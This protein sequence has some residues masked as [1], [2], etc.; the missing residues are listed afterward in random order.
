[1]SLLIKALHKAEQQKTSGDKSTTSAAGV[2][3]EL[4]P[5]DAMIKES[6][7]FLKNEPSAVL[8]QASPAKLLQNSAA[9]VFAAKS[10]DVGTSTKTLIL[11]GL[12]LLILIA[13]G[14]YYYLESLN[15]TELLIPSHAVEVVSNP[16]LATPVAVDEPVAPT[17][18]TGTNAPAVDA[19]FA[20]G[21]LIPDEPAE[22]PPVNDGFS[23]ASTTSKTSVP[24]SAAVFGDKPASASEAGVKVTRHNPPP[25]INPKLANAYEAF[26]VGDDATAQANYRQ[27][28]QTDIRNTDAL[29]GMAAVALRQGRS[30]DAMGWYAKVLEVE[31]R[32]SFAQA[33]MVSLL[34]QTDPVSSESRIKSLLALQPHAAHLHAALGHLY[35]EQNQWSQAQQSYFE[36]HRLDA[37]NAEYAFN[38]AVSLDQLSKPTLALQ[39][40]RQALILLGEKSESTIDRG[41]LESRIVQLQ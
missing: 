40:Y 15:Q 22:R 14:F 25:A 17:A 28:L 11:T 35:S 18:E 4:A 5:K 8:P 41:L 1:M 37:G 21:H 3:L 10:S 31:P 34:G 2:G 19:S 7:S 20:A 9:V 12:V 32:N 24:S 16:S 26:N 23:L 13:S 36:A 39:Y 6:P 27:V 33:A 29:L 30:N 38:L